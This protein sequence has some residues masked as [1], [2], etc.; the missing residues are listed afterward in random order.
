MCLL[1]VCVDTGAGF[2]ALPEVGTLLLAAKV[3]QRDEGKWS[4]SVYVCF[5]Q[6]DNSR[7]LLQC[8]CVSVCNTM[9]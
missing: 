5:G 7:V 6:S 4:F 2:D 9:K 8:A 1:I 3:L